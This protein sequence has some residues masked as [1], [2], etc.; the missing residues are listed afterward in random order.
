M[1]VS[2]FLLRLYF[3]VQLFWCDKVAAA[4]AANFELR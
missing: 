4:M 1:Q 2:I 3:D